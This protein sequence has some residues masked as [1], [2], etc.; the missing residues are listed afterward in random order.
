M[1]Q[2]I[3][4]S[5]LTSNISNPSTKLWYK[6]GDKDVFFESE[7]GCKFFSSVVLQCMTLK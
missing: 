2:Y 7:K 5:V 3:C 4:F 1:L 6:I